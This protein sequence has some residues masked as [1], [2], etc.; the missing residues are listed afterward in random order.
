M[1]SAS[2]RISETGGR[3]HT[4]ERRRQ[5]DHGHGDCSDAVKERQRP[6]ELEEARME[7]SLEHLK[8]L[9]PA[10]N[11]DF[12]PADADVGL[13]SHERISFYC[14]RPPIKLVGTFTVAL[15]TNTGHNLQLVRDQAPS[16]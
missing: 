6:P 14:F 5:R 16:T 4:Q 8:E 3:Q 12:S 9:G 1:S 7:S 11:L 15:G 2:A 10:E 13:Q